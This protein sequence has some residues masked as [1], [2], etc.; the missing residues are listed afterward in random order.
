MINKQIADMDLKDYVNIKADK[1]SGGNKRKLSVAIAIIGNPPIVFLDEP[2]T[3]V[4]P[5]A[6]RFMWSIVSKISTQRKKS[7]VII[8]THSMEEAEALCTKMGIM[9][10]G[11]FKCFGST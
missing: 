9:V 1:L 5:K 7:S 4:D 10:A 3:G 8:T 11:K 6:R 2:S